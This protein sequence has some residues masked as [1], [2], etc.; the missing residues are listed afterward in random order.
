[1]KYQSD[2]CLINKECLGD[3]CLHHTK[4]RGASGSDKEWNL[5]PL[6]VFHHNQVHQKGLNYM[7]KT[8]KEVQE[9]LLDNDWEFDQ[10]SNRWLHAQD[11]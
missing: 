1:M 11:K 3:Y 6:C 9:W 2:H 7:V 8:Y 5:M 10:F 4:T